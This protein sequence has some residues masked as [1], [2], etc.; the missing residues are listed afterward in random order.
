MAVEHYIYRDWCRIYGC[1]CLTFRA[2]EEPTV[3]NPYYPPG[4]SKHLDDGYESAER[5]R[6]AE[7]EFER[8]ENARDEFNDYV[9]DLISDGFEYGDLTNALRKWRA[10]L[11]R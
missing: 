8:I 6:D 1:Q 2:L 9:S 5:E 11:T 4:A 3:S 7:R 10:G